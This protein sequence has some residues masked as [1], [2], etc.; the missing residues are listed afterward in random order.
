MR[1][2]AVGQFL[3]RS[4]VGEYRKVAWSSRCATPVQRLLADRRRRVLAAV[5]S[6]RGLTAAGDMPP[7][8]PFGT[9]TWSDDVDGTVTP[10]V[11]GVYAEVAQAGAQLFQPASQGVLPVPDYAAQV[12][13][14][15]GQV[16]GLGPDT[17]AAI[18]RTLTAGYAAGEHYDQLAARV[19]DEFGMADWRALMITRTEVTR[20]V[21]ELNNG[22]ALALRDSG[23]TMVKQWLD[24]ENAC[25]ACVE[26]AQEGSVPAD[27]AFS[28]GSY[29]PPDPHPNCRCSLAYDTEGGPVVS[30]LGEG[31]YPG[32]VWDNPETA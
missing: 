19:A 9:D 1:R 16:D 5:R 14:L 22:Y 26:L 21:E 15:V 30:Q 20:G 18:G 31:P 27:G 23:L 32:D 11:Q 10:A 28:D 17:A 7:S 12:G 6:D 8:D 3:G 25:P 4:L 13:R 2:Q 24:S 29:A